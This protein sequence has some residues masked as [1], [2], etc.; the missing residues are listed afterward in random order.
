M[1]SPAP[2]LSLAGVRKRFGDHTALSDIDLTVGSGE[3]LGIIGRSGAG[4]STLIRC[5][6]GLER[7]D[8]GT[9][10]IEGREIQALGE[11]ALKPVRR[12]IG[13][14]FQHF[15][16]L[17]NRTA[18]E[19]IELPLIIAGMAR[20]PRQARVR[21]LLQLVGLEGRED[22]YPAQLSGGQKQR[23]GIARALAP[24]PAMLLSDEATS[25]LDP[26]TTEQILA[27][28]A[29]INRRLGLTI[30]LITHE[31][32]VVR[33]IAGRVVVLENG[34]IA[35]A[36]ETW[37]VFADPQAAVTKSLLGHD[38]AALPPGLVLAPG[39]SGEALI[40]ID[41][42]GPDAGAPLLSDLGARFGASAR[43]LSGG[44]EP[45][46]GVPVGRL[47]VGV[48]PARPDDLEPILAHLASSTIRTEL[49]GHVVRA[50]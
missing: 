44:V 12:R 2:I 9:V 37:R 50:D 3:I 10:A 34:R 40:R 14:V 36:G 46:G 1:T 32:D 15:N 16:L 35:E 43:I 11:S 20:G 22:R 42:G 17:A 27:L 28:L 5:I 45:V 19:N 49:L 24:E 30:L 8:A 13:M 41:L 7:P 29:D 48:T 26:E 31:M 6:N 39:G 21:D 33:R 23:V 25:A 47:F 4:K 38:A 18:A